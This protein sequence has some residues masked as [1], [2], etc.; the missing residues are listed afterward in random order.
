M[1]VEVIVPSVDE[2]SEPENDRRLRELTRILAYQIIERL[3]PEL[4]RGLPKTP[5]SVLIKKGGSKLS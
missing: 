1:K 2:L 4:V 3:Y 5:E